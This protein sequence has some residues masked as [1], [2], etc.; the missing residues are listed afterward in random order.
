[1]NI[2]ERLS[3]VETLMQRDEISRE[4]ATEQVKA[5]KED[6]FVAIEEGDY[7]YAHDMIMDD[8]GLEPDYLDELIF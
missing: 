8:L 7:N 2:P 1:M 3:I 6:L 4:E 5:F